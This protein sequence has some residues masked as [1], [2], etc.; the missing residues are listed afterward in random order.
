M[1][2]FLPIIQGAGRITVVIDNES[3]NSQDIT[4]FDG[5]NDSKWIAVDVRCA[6]VGV[7]SVG[8]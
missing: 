5:N 4:S 7:T 1:S 2:L 3:L 8:L 6:A